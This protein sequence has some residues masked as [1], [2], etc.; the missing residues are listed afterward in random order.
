MPMVQPTRRKK[1]NLRFPEQPLTLLAR[2]SSVPKAMTPK[3]A[4]LSPLGRVDPT[5]SP[6]KEKKVVKEKTRFK[7]ASFWQLVQEE[8]VGDCKANEFIPMAKLRQVYNFVHVLIHLEKVLFFGFWVCLD[9]FLGVF[10]FLPVR[11][12][13]AIVQLLFG[14]LFRSLRISRAQLFEALRAWIFVLSTAFLWFYFD[15]S[16]I[17]HWVRQQQ[18]I[19]LW[20]LFNILEVSF[21]HPWTP[22]LSISK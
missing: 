17:Y 22:S 2:R 8:F 7:K 4:A 13:Y 19:R 14:W 11:L 18:A 15:T 1:R 16:H 3:V 6:T 10:S 5:P 20:V 21:L 9:A 12:G